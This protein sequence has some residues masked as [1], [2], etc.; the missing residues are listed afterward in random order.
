MVRS[1]E[2]NRLGAVLRTCLGF[3]GAGNLPVDKFG[4][5]AAF[6]KSFGQ[7]LVVGLEGFRSGGDARPTDG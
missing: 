7:R 1:D 5:I 2:R 4:R 3:G 6:G